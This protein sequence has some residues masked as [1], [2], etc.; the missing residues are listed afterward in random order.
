M[1]DNAFPDVLGYITGGDR[2]NL[3]VVQIAPGVRPKI[4]QAGRPFEI[5]LVVQNACDAKVDVT[6]NLHL[7]K[8]FAAKSARV[9][10]G[11]TPAE[12]GY[13]SLP[14]TAAHNITANTYKLGLEVDAKPLSKPNRVRTV[15]GG[16]EFDVFVL[17]E[18]RAKR[19]DA[20]RR[21]SFAFNKRMGIGKNLLEVSVQVAPAAPNTADNAALLA[22]LGDTLRFKVLPQLKRDSIVNPLTDDT[23]RRFNEAGYNLKRPEALMIAKV[24]AIIL[25]YAAP[26]ENSHDPL[27]AGDYNLTPMLTGSK[28]VD[29]MPRWARAML[30]LIARDDRATNHAVAAVIRFLYDELLRDAIDYAFALVEV[31]TGENVGSDTEKAEYANHLLN[32][33]SEKAG[34]DFIYVYMPLVIAGITINERITP[35]E[36][37]FVEA[38]R[39]LWLIMDERRVE[40]DYQGQPV[41]EMANQVIERALQTYGYRRGST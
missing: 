35:K 27:Q 14:I 38:L 9:V 3:G 33:L 2:I 41:L 17:P 1:S 40:V 34:L 37:N 21:A 5:A 15:E 23:L 20:V 30:R 25:E 4:A 22:R 28:K 7:P 36:D 19:V 39:E 18:D 31:N 6:I 24:M 13:V 12:V 16:E 10:V 26:S 29:A 8:Q 32:A 11:L